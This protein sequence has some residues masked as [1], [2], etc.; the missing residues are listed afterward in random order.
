MSV[1]L[2]E[3]RALQADVRD[4]ARVLG[5]TLNFVAALAKDPEDRVAL[6]NNQEFCR[7]LYKHHDHGL[8]S[9]GYG[10]RMDRYDSNPFDPEIDDPEGQS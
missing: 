9:R 1:E 7:L 5:E 4:L 6:R 10:I 8:M 2:Y 3:F